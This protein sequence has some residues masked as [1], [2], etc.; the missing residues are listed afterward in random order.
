MGAIQG[1]K[2]DYSKQ[3]IQSLHI[4]FFFKSL[5]NYEKLII[6]LKKSVL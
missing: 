4:A 3:K 2:I 5:Q 6:I 1:I